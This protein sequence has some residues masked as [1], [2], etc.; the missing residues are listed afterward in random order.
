LSGWPEGFSFFIGSLWGIVILFVIKATCLG[1]L[2]PA[3]TYAAIGMIASMA[4]EV[5][6]PE[7]QVPQAM[8]YTVFVGLI[9]GLFYLLPIVFTLPD[10][11]TL[12]DGAFNFDWGQ[13]WHRC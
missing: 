4:E 3:Y 6:D 5:R 12:L 8:F 1:L 11:N 9:S 10:I 2:P 7:L 13:S